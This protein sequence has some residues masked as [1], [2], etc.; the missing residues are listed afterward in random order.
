MMMKSK[1]FGEHLANFINAIKAMAGSILGGGNTEM[2]R[3]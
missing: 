3:H 2:F 1:L